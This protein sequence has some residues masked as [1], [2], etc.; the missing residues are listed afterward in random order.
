MDL[1]QVKT[2]YWEIMQMRKGRRRTIQLSGLMTEME[3]EWHIPILEMNVGSWLAR[4]PVERKKIYHMY[5]EIHSKR[6]L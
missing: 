6:D 3:R 1:K 4:D 5:L 2:K